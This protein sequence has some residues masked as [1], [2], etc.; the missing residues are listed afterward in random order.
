MA[1][2]VTETHT[3][4]VSG[5]PT[6]AV[7]NSAGTISIARGSSEEVHLVVTKRARGLFGGGSEADLERVPVTVKQEGETIRVDAWFRG[8]SIAKA[9]TVD[10][11]FTIPATANLDLRVA[12][13]NV[14]VADVSGALRI[15]VNAGNSDLRNVS[16]PMRIEGNAGNIEGY[17]MALHERCELKVNAGNINVRGEMAAG[18]SLETRVNTGNISLGLPRT[19][20]VRLEASAQVG[21]VTIQGWPISVSRKLV[22]QSA[23]GQ[24]QPGASDRLN[25]RVDAGNITIYAD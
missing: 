12:A 2:T 10:L 11:E 9:V 17:G 7:R 1:A 25:A 18:A 14:R 24:T 15:E 5:T 16:G 19:T 21:N 13:G 6:I 23:S 22:Q 8:M 4:P 20:A 3:L